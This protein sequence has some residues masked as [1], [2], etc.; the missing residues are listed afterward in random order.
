MG[1]ACRI[2]GE[3]HI[4]SLF[5]LHNTL[6]LTQHF[7]WIVSSFCTQ[8]KLC[9]FFFSSW[10]RG[11]LFFEDFFESTEQSSEL[12]FGSAS[13]V[14]CMHVHSELKPSMQ[15]TSTLTWLYYPTIFDLT[16]DP[17]FIHLF[18]YSTNVYRN[19][20]WQ[21]TLMGTRNTAMNK[22]EWPHVFFWKRIPSFLVIG[23]SKT[24]LCL[25]N[26]FSWLESL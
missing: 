4:L 13:C 22:T 5:F 26:A 20:L 23:P 10:S 1:S 9:S 21:C 12:F 24:N 3:R 2:Y 16:W 15:L 8:I 18:F 11:H 19:P 6:F 7:P 14:L 17:V 25:V